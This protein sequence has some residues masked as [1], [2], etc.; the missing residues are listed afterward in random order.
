MIFIQ[1]SENRRKMQGVIHKK[2]GFGIALFLLKSVK[3]I[4]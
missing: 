3:W 4:L 2:N 1:F